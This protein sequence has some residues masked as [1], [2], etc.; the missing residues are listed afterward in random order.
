MQNNEQHIS[1]CLCEHIRIYL[2]IICISISFVFL[3]HPSSIKVVDRETLLKEREER[4]KVKLGLLVE[5]RWIEKF[6][7]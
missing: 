1:V 5:S 6:E 2:Y 3:G 4:L 7:I